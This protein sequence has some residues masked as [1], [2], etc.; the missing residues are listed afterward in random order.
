MG[1]PHAKRSTRAGSPV[2]VECG[3]AVTET[4]GL[5]GTPLISAC[6]H[7][8]YFT[9][10]RTLVVVIIGDRRPARW[11]FHWRR[12]ATRLNA[13]QVAECHVGKTALGVAALPWCR[14][15]RLIV[16]YSRIIGVA[17]GSIMPTIMMAHIIKIRL[18][19]A[20]ARGTAWAD[21]NVF[22]IA[23]IPVAIDRRSSHARTVAPPTLASN[24][25]WLCLIKVSS[26]VEAVWLTRASSYSG[27]RLRPELGENMGDVGKN[28][29]G[30]VPSPQVRQ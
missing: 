11:R 15:L 22:S 4:A 23:S 3:L 7:K 1:P 6:C 13:G 14:R 16:V 26:V 30:G 9:Q 27:Y 28:E 25:S 5:D 18:K 29:D 24:H 19:S 12:G 2:A 20:D 8:R 17:I 21:S 10:E